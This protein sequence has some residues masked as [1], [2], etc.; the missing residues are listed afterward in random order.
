MRCQICNRETNS[1]ELN[2]HTGKYESICSVCR[3]ASRKYP[4]FNNCDT[5][6]ELKGE[7]FI[8]FLKENQDDTDD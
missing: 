7:E 2:K 8:N 3:S 4:S 1:W 6:E 5:L